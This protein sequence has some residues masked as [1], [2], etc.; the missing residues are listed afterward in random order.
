MILPQEYVPLNDY[1]GIILY[2][3]SI[4][5]S[6]PD[7]FYYYTKGLS[8]AYLVMLFGIFVFHYFFF[9]CYL[10]RQVRLPKNQRSFIQKHV[11]KTIQ[12]EIIPSLLLFSFSVFIYSMTIQIFI[13][14]L[15]AMMGYS[16]SILGNAKNIPLLKVLGR[17][18]NTYTLL[19]YLIMCMSKLYWGV[20]YST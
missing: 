6:N 8:I 14:F 12:Q 15:V 13:T 17:I 7:S 18:L 20:G 16:L 3:R 10:W 11:H 19:V 4:N 9:Y 1:K 5:Y 2:N